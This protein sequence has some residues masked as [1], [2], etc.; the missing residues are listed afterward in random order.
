MRIRVIVLAGAIVALAGGCNTN[1]TQPDV[2]KATS[3]T[4]KAALQSQLAGAF[5]DFAEAYFGSGL[6]SS[7]IDGQAQEGQVIASAL[8]TDEMHETDYF[9]N[10]LQVD[11]RTADRDNITVDDA[12]RLIQRARLSAEQTALN[13]T[14]YDPTNTGRLTVLNLDGFAFV[15][16]AETFC[17][18]VPIS[19][20]DASGNITYGGP[21]GTDSLLHAAEA[22]FRQVISLSTSD[23]SATAD[24]AGIATEV[25]RANVGLARAL[26]DEGQYAAAGVAAGN[27]PDGFADTVERSS[28]S[29]AEQNGVY[30]YTN[31][32]VRYAVTSNE[33]GVGLPF[34]ISGDPRIVM[35]NPVS[36]T[37]GLDG[38]STDSI[39]QLY[40][41]YGSPGPLATAIEARLIEAE[42]AMQAGNSGLYLSKINGVR[43]LYGLSALSDPGG[44]A[45]VDTLFTE[46]AY[47]LW[48]TGH[49]VGDLRR[50]MRQYGRAENTV[51]PSGTYFKNN[52]QYGNQVAFPIPREEDNNPKYTDAACKSGTVP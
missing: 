11:L 45:R 47:D 24:T 1:V 42:A 20:V 46:R 2:V 5:G 26:L 51:W 33:G 4:G 18:N 38:V 23:L 52:L 36:T 14:T 12:Y 48:L 8:F 16:L 25:N 17:A 49:R 32:E 37:L 22:K 7:F 39:Q 21:V 3:V 44:T 19:S 41:A 29:P 6:S 43:A 40:P 50:L 28:N 31:I 27:V 13:F 30:Y 9:T 15:L 34:T 35:G 10:H